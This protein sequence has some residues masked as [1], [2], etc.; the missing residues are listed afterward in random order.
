MFDRELL[1]HFADDPTVIA[2]AVLVALDFVL[3]TCAAFYTNVFR[4]SFFADTFRNDVLGKMIPYYALWAALHVGGVD[5]SVGGFDVIEETSG[6]VI[7]L[8][9]IGSV[10]A[11]L[12]ALGL[13]RSV[14]VSIAGPDPSSPNPT[15]IETKPV[16]THV[17]K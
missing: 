4:L 12:A 3:G 2:I 10:T 17:T 8:A 13:L 14:P 7:L 16:T 15:P 5:W 1:N 11:S 9:L 6:A